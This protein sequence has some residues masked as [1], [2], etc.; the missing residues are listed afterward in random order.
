MVTVLFGCKSVTELKRMADCNYEFLSVSNVKLAGVGIDGMNN[1]KD[2]KF[3]DLGVI[4]QTYLTGK[5]PVK[6]DANV[7]IQNPNDKTASLEKLDWKFFI[8]DVEVTSGVITDKVTIESNQSIILPIKVDLDLME[9]MKD[10]NKKTIYNFAFSLAE[11]DSHTSKIKIKIKPAVKVAGKLVSTPNY[12]TI[13]ET[14]G[15]TK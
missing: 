14:V 11:I 1:L 13:T 6:F 8:E 10:E 7:G 15:E 3:S 12:F 4:T 2:L 5:L 9:L